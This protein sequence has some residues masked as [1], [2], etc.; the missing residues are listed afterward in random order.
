[1]IYFQAGYGNEAARRQPWIL[2]VD[3]EHG[4]YHAD[5]NT[6]EFEWAR[7]GRTEVAQGYIDTT[8][9][10]DASVS[11]SVP[12]SEGAAV[13]V[14]LRWDMSATEVQ[15]S[16]GLAGGDR[17]F[18]RCTTSNYLFNRRFRQGGTVTGSLDGVDTASL[19]S[20]QWGLPY[21]SGRAVSTFVV[22]EHSPACVA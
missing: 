8:H 17:Y 15:N 14:D 11:G 18:D 10:L 16:N 19:Y 20:P 22:T 1:M 5:T 12:M 13:D 21:V 3:E 7:S 6:Y 2:A 9:M 4:R